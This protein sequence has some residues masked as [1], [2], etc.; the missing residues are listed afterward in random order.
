MAHVVTEKCNGC[1]FTDCVEVCPCARHLC[2]RR[3]SFGIH[4]RH[5]VQRCRGQ[6]DQGLRRAGNH[7]PQRCAAD[8]ERPKKSA[9][10]LDCRR[11]CHSRKHSGFT[12]WS[13]WDVSDMDRR[14][15]DRLSGSD[16]VKRP[17]A[18]ESPI[19]SC[20]ETQLQPSLLRCY[21]RSFTFYLGNPFPRFLS[22]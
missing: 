18:F 7:S 6:P 1:K 9:R 12:E 14:S 19:F 11:L 15:A 3:R 22:S 17:T 4:E 8:C 21:P 5:R 2:G 10:L 16:R 13:R 20:F